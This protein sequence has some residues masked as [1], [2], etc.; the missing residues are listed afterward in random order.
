[1]SEYYAVVRSTDHLAH[2][3]VV[4]MKWGVRRA[5]AKGNERALDR[6]FRRAAKKLKKLTDI[7][8]NS[9]KYAA[10]AAAYGVA[11]AGTG[12]VAVAGTKGIASYLHKKAMSKIAGARAAEMGASK[13]KSMIYDP[14]TG[15]SQFKNATARK[16]SDEAE[17]LHRKANAIDKWG[18]HRKVTKTSIIDEEKL[19]GGKKKFIIKEGP[20]KVGMS[21]NDKLRIGAAVATAGLAAKAAQNAYRASHGAEYRNK[22]LAYKNAMDEVFSGTKYEGKYVAEPRRKKKARR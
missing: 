12:T 16:L 11:A 13:S 5:L 7:G 6:N 4:G 20:D 3:G 18:E 1:M 15:T 9:K 14:Y 21:R 2:Y 17:K 10:K 8:L 19:S 22:A